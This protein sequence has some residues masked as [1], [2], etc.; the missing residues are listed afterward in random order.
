MTLGVLR[1][2]ALEIEMVSLHDKLDAMKVKAAQTTQEYLKLLDSIDS[3]KD[4]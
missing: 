3:K 4:N 2:I 1:I